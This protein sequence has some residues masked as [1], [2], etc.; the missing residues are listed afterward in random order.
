MIT[1]TSLL[2]PTMIVKIRNGIKEAALSK[3]KHAYV[4]NRKGRN[5]M[6]IDWHD[7]TDQ[8]SASYTVW[9][10][11]DWGQ[12]DVTQKVKGAVERGCSSNR[13]K[14]RTFDLESYPNESHTVTGR[15]RF[16]L[17]FTGNFF[18]RRKIMPT[19]AQSISLKE[20]ASRIVSFDRSQDV[21]RGTI[22]MFN[23][24]NVEGRL[25]QIIDKELVS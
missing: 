24:N 5:I 1:T 13:V 20:A 25:S 14:P 21:S 18:E 10:G 8:R 7:K 15:L 6:R 3:L 23:M 2:H 4:K 12:M 19:P 16:P 9:G 11:S 17:A 22:R